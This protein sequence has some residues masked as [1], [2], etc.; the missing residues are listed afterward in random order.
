MRGLSTPCSEALHALLEP[1]EGVSIA[2][3]LRVITDQE[4]SAASDYILTPIG[5]RK[6]GLSLNHVVGCPINC[7]YCVRHMFGN[8]EMKVPRL[9]A[10]SREVVEQLLSNRYFQRDKTPLQILNKATDPFLSAVKPYLFETLRL[11]AE[12]GLRNHVL[13]ITR[14]KVT[15][16]EADELNQFLPLKLTLLVTRSGIV[17][18]RLEPISSTI[19]V[20]TL[21]TTYQRAEN[22]KVIQYWRPLIPGINDSDSHIEQAAELSLS[23][24]AT[25]FTGLFHRKEM[26]EYYTSVG[27]S[28]PYA[29]TARRKI[30]PRDLE[31]Q[32]ITNFNRRGGRLLFKKTS[33]GVSF[34]HRQADYNGHYGLREELCQICPRSQVERCAASWRKPT[35]E[36]VRQVAGRIGNRTAFAVGDRAI[37]FF[38][39]PE[40]DRYYFQH[41]LGFQAHNSETPHY[42]GRHGRAEIGWSP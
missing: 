21:K 34:A 16:K 17:D 1:T 40:S 13:V 28:V 30:L 4:R 8:Y 2:L 24:H 5:Y 38:A 10:S 41:S 15:E 33:C 26:E 35:H 7:A 29:Q 18:S 32:V 19:A 14:S 25:V 11:L 42:P 12:A 31:R 36:D 39:L 23:A 6:S 9:I 27:L 22:Y 3:S 37:T 20:D